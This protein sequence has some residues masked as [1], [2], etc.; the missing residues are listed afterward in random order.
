M[1]WGK[2]S[3]GTRSLHGWPWDICAFSWKNKRRPPPMRP[4]RL[5]QP[6]E[7]TQPHAPSSPESHLLTTAIGNLRPSRCFEL[8]LTHTIPYQGLCW[9]RPVG[10]TAQN[11]HSA[12][13]NISAFQ[14]SDPPPLPRAFGR[15]SPWHRKGRSAER[16]HH[17]GICCMWQFL[18]GHHRRGS[19]PPKSLPRW[20]KGKP[21][22]SRLFPC[23]GTNFSLGSSYMANALD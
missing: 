2:Y 3:S 8:S 11:N 12:K 15:R 20:R 22:M 21:H 16:Q 17:Q 5:L 23:R 10:V 1:P 13:E 14:K 18:V 9:K 4:G 6:K 19:S 7:D